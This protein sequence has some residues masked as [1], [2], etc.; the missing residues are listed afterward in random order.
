MAIAPAFA[1]TPYTPAVRINTANTARDGTGTLG[2]LATGGTTGARIDNIRV[3]A[4]AATTAGMIRLFRSIAGSA[5]TK[6]LIAEIPVDAITP[7]A[8]LAA[9]EADVAFPGGLILAGDA[10]TPQELYVGTHAAESFDI[11]VTNGARL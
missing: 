4:N 3:K 1:S 2:T 8:S 6:Y 7:T 11:S 9:F 5:A 10:T